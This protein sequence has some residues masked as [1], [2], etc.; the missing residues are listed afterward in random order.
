[1]P[2]MLWTSATFAL[3]LLVLVQSSWCLLRNVTVDD[4]YGDP[5]TG[6][7]PTYGPVIYGNIWHFGPS[8]NDCHMT[9]VID[10]SKTS[11]NTWHDC[12]WVPGNQPNYVAVNFEGEDSTY[13]RKKLH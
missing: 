5:E 1:M 10:Q 11:N 8:C 12:T 13:Y 9:Q 6:E 4:E 3:L 7:R 2:Y